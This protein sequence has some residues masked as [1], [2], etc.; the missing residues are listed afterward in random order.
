MPHPDEINGYDLMNE[1]V[2][3]APEPEPDEQDDGDRGE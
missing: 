2:V 3:S 1:E